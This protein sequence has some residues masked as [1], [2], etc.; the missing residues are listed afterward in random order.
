MGAVDFD[1]AP[2]VEPDASRLEAERPRR[3]VRGP[4]ASTSQST[5]ICSPAAVKVTEVLPP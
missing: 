5:S 1:Q 2:L 4:S 3:R